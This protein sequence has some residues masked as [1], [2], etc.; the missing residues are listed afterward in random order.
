MDKNKYSDKFRK[1]VEIPDYLEWDVMK[2]GIYEK[3]DEIPEGK[4]VRNLLRWSILILIFLLST[5]VYVTYENESIPDKTRQDVDYASKDILDED[6]K[7]SRNSEKSTTVEHGEHIETSRLKVESAIETVSEDSKTSY[8]GAIFQS[9]SSKD[10]DNSLFS[11]LSNNSLSNQA[12]SEASK[13]SYQNQNLNK[14]HVAHHSKPLIPNITMDIAND[15]SEDKRLEALDQTTG[16]INLFTESTHREQSEPLPTLNGRQKDYYPL[17]LFPT[18]PKLLPGSIPITSSRLQAAVPT[19][20]EHEDDQGRPSLFLPLQL[21]VKQGFGLWNNSVSISNIDNTNL[22]YTNNFAFN[23]YA[24][25]SSSINDKWSIQAGIKYTVL[26]S[27]TNYYEE[28]D[29][30]VQT[31]YVSKQII[32][33]LNGKVIEERSSTVNNRV[34]KWSKIDYTNQLQYIGMPVTVSRNIPVSRRWDVFLRLGV[35]YGYVF[36]ATGRFISNQSPTDFNDQNQV[37]KMD[38]T[39]TNNHFLSFTTAAGIR[40]SLNQK[41]SL[42]LD[43]SRNRSLT[44]VSS[45][46]RLRLRPNSFSSSLGLQY[47]L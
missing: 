9:K 36:S 33:K 2:D 20:A 21:E 6:P 4:P 23:T 3:M 38:N 42:L 37:I 47:T 31:E 12:N 43:I 18:L 30:I 29:T 28:R 27:R 32:N 22:N 45:H 40:F 19:I 41:T 10:V 13:L 24:G 16:D 14:E 7:I 8:H 5:C 11:L 25:L 15:V 17:K 35:E 1:E 34:T 26:H 46:S 44:D 39:Q